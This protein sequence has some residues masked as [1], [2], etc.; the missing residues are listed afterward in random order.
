MLDLTLLGTGGM[1]PLPDR[2]LTSLIVKHNGFGILFDCGEGTQMALHKHGLSPK[3][4]DVIF[5]THLHADHTAGLP[6][7]LLKLVNAGRAEPVSVIG[8]KGTAALVEAVKRIALGITFE[9]SVTELSSEYEIF[10]LSLINSSKNRLLEGLTVS[11]FLVDHSVTCYGYSL[12]L[13]RKGKFS[14]QKAED[15][16]IEKRYWRLLQAGE[17]VN[18]DGATYAP[19]MVL[20][21]PR[22]GLKVTYCTDTTPTASV[23][24]NS[25]GADVLVLEGMYGDKDKQDDADQKKHMMMQAAAEIAAKAGA[26]ELWLTH[27]SPAEI[28]PERYVDEIATIFPNTMIKQEGITKTLRF[29]EQ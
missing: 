17:E 11:A 1:M 14:A 2:Y 5:L 3:Q 29:E 28:E 10:D 21:A 9:L 27:F 12:E 16:G 6:G 15:L 22:K 25:R 7:F 8:P 19:D 4:V 23:S 26:K 24:E 20:G 13:A 18:I